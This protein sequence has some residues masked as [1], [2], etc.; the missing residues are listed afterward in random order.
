M[1]T[2]AAGWVRRFLFFY[3]KFL[4]CKP[5][6]PDLHLPIKFFKF[7]LKNMIISA[8]KNLTKRFGLSQ[9]NL[10]RKPLEGFAQVNG[11]GLIV[12]NR[13]FFSE[14]SEEPEPEPT[15]EI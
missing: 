12:G 9:K 14:N 5:Q 3:S 13:K 8:L 1:V 4:P 15:E 11:R 2:V 7:I 10:P 6:N